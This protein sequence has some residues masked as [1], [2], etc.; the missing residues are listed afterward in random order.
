MKKYLAAVKTEWQ[1]QMTYRLEFISFRLGNVLEISIQLIIW[2]IVFR[3]Q[4]IINGYNYN[5]MITYIVIGWL[6]L[7][8]TGNYGFEGIVSI[9]IK[10]GTLS[11]FLTKPVSYL[12]YIIFLSIGRISL[13]L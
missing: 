10:D 6:F 11:N 7:F 5:E 4:A 8:L 12:R 9:Q 3:S 2:T 1:R 13:A